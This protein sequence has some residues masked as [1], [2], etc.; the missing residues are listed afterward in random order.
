MWLFISD[1]T[2]L[3]SNMRAYDENL[4]WL[5][6]DDLNIEDEEKK[7][8]VGALIRSFY[9]NSKFEENLASGI[10]VWKFKL[11]VSVDK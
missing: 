6:P 10:M 7:R 2:V 11:N 1:L 8:M 3:K 5:V 4:S 9:T